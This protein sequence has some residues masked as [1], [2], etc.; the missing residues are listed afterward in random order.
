MASLTEQ[1]FSQAERNT[2]QRAVAS[3]IKLDDIVFLQNWKND[4]EHYLFFFEMIRARYP[5]MSVDD[6]IERFYKFTIDVLLYI[7]KNALKTEEDIQECNNSVNIK[8]GNAIVFNTRCRN[9]DTLYARANI[10]EGRIDY[11]SSKYWTQGTH[12][13]GEFE[14]YEELF[15]EQLSEDPDYDPDAETEEELDAYEDNP[16]KK[17][18]VWISVKDS[19]TADV[20]FL[21]WLTLIPETKAAQ[22]MNYELQEPTPEPSTNGLGAAEEEVESRSCFDAI[23]QSDEDI[24]EYLAEDKNNFVIKLPAPS[25]NYECMSMDYLKSQW[26]VG[27]DERPDLNQ[28]YYKR[29]YECQEKNN[30]PSPDNVMTNLSYIKIGSSLFLVEKPYWIYN[31]V[32]PEPRIFE[33]Y[34][35]KQVTTITSS[36][37]IDGNLF[38]YV[39]G[40]HCN[41]DP[42]TSYRLVNL[43]ETPTDTSV[44]PFES[45]MSP[46]PLNYNPMEPADLMDNEDGNGDDPFSGSNVARS[47]SFSE[48]DQGARD[49]DYSRSLIFSE[50]GSQRRSHKKKTRGNKSKRKTMSKSKSKSKTK[51]RTKTKSNTKSKRKSIKLKKQKQK[52]SKAKSIK[53]KKQQKRKLSTTKRNK[54]K[55]RN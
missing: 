50:G 37:M 52:A 9:I 11:D 34:P 6:M 53:G 28:P 5:N 8:P 35:G 42:L 44:E 40:D 18:V 16:E 17:N 21:L 41:T 45:P 54:S 32:P 49:Q 2:I 22:L 3:F 51:S 29:W 38:N 30:T 10:A 46:P 7:R 15:L 55:K 20:R 1:S 23:M 13:R 48:G 27:A 43:G 36:D 31:G 4:V 26:S 33:L 12:R 24:K 25:N 14:V 19:N 39:S 47:L